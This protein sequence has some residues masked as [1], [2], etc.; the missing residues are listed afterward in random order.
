MFAHQSGTGGNVVL[1]VLGLVAVIFEVNGAALLAMGGSTLL[2]G[3]AMLGLGS[4]CVALFVLVWRRR[5]AARQSATLSPIVTLDFA[6]GVLLDHDGAVL[7]PLAQVTFSSTMQLASSARALECRWG[8]GK[9]L[10]VLRGDAFGGGIGPAV[11]AL[12]RK[13]LRF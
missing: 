6:R 4:A 9:A 10:V 1:F 2:P 11:D 8:S 13:G 5:A 12:K 7:A 3:L